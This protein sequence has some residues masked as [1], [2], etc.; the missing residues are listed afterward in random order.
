MIRIFSDVGKNRIVLELAGSP[1][2]EDIAHASKELALA[3]PRL[4]PPID[5]MSDVSQLDS[6]DGVTQ[7]EFERL[8]LM[9]QAVGVR[10]VVRVVGRSKEGA[11][12]MQRMTRMF[13]HSAHLAFSRE[14]AENVLA[15][16]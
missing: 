10:R 9:L 11:L 4:R 8:G 6:L 5:V 1:T 7:A 16:R 2:G 14:E 12:H 13:R 3:L 15:L